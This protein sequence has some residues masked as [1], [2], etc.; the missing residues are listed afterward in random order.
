LN[1]LQPLV[2][3]M[4]IPVLFIS[5]LL[6]LALIF[7]PAAFGHVPVIPEGNDVL[8][9]A[10]VVSDPAKSWA[11]YGHLKEADEVHYYRFEV[12]KGE[13]ILVSLYAS[14]DPEERD[15]LPSLA[16]MGPGIESQGLPAAPVE[17]PDGAGVMV[18]EG[19]QPERV[20][21]EPFG[22]SSFRSLGAID[23]E[24]P[25]TGPYYV[26][27]YDQ[28]RGGH[29]GVTVGYVEIFSVLERITTPIRLVSV[30][31]WSG[32]SLALIFVPAVAVILLGLFLIWKILRD[33]D[34]PGRL[35]S[36]AG[37]L[38]LAT[39]GSILFQMAFS[40]AR[41]PELSEAPV[42]L[43]LA[44]APILLGS[45]ALAI[46][47]GDGLKATGRIVLFFVGMIGLFVGAGFLAGPLMA[48]LASM[49]PSK[50]GTSERARNLVRLR[51]RDK[52][53][54]F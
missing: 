26:A 44:S 37:L 40:L 3:R 19:R 12:Y 29:Y 1:L 32:E 4:G 46:S 36:L 11:F 20:T 18:L 42:T 5:V 45:V 35:G 48:L 16:L 21:Y 27:V 14:A 41:A 33:L 43:A 53:R 25:A 49:I 9:E 6:L 8:S 52:T 7:I 54:V 10:T 23:L 38:F 34:A 2:G 17:V 50:R 28:G 39:G 30:Y 47:L 24:S 51:N 13:R 31:R 22:P 15:F